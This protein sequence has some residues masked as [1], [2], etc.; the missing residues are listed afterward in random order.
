MSIAHKKTRARRVKIRRPRKIKMS[1]FARS[2][3]EPNRPFRDPLSGDRFMAK[4]SIL[5]DEPE[6]TL[7]ASARLWVVTRIKKLGG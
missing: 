3:L 2:E 7:L 5:A 6:P 4:K 1:D